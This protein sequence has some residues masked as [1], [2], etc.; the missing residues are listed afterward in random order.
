MISIEPTTG[1]FTHEHEFLGVEFDWVG[2]DITGRLGYFSTAGAGPIPTICMDHPGMF[3]ELFESVLGAPVI[4]EPTQ[5]S[6]FDKNI[7][8]W[9]EVTKRGFYSFD[10]SSELLVYQLVAIPTP[11]IKINTSNSNALLDSF[12]TIKL[13]CMFE[14]IGAGIL[15]L[16]ES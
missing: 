16:S 4:S 13:N 12:N 7:S 3:D 11:P 9:M 10:W 2:A 1:D 15:S 14:K 5:I 8:D 6:A